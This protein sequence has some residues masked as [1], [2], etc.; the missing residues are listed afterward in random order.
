M[1][2]KNRSRPLVD[3]RQQHPLGL[4]ELLKT[5]GHSLTALGR[6]ICHR[7]NLVKFGSSRPQLKHDPLTVAHS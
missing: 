7:M 2:S 4:S 1:T 6:G 5:P 3:V